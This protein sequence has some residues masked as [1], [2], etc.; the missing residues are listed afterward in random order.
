M[1]KL[2]TILTLLLISQVLHAQA[3]QATSYQAVIRNS[4]GN[5]LFNQLVKVR[6]SIHDSAA[7]GTVVYQ[8]TQTPTTNAQGLINLFAGQGTAVTGTFAGINWGNK[9]KF[10]QTEIDI[11]G[12]NNYADMGTTQLMSVPYALYSNNGNPNGTAVGEMLYW[13]GTTW[14][15]LNP[16]TN[17]QNLTF[18]NGVPQWGPCLILPIV[19]TGSITTKTAISATAG[20]N[21]TDSGSAKI[22]ARGVCFSTTINPTIANTKTASGTNVIGAYTVSLNGLSSL[23]TYHYRAYATTSVGTSYGAD[24]VFTTNAATIPTLTTTAASAITGVTATSGGNI[25]SDNG[26]TITARGIC[27]STTANPTITLTTKTIDGSGTGAFTSSIIGLATNTLYYVRA[28]ATNSAGTAYGTQVSFTTLRLSAVTTGAV[29]N[30]TNATATASGNVTDSGS[31]AITARGFCYATTPSPTI[32]N[33]TVVANGTNTTG[34][35]TVSLTG[36]LANTRYYV[37][38]YVTTS[39][40]TSY[41]VDSVFTTTNLVASL[42]RITIGTQV[43]TNKNLDV[44]TY[45]NGDPIPQVT[46]PTQWTNLTTGAWCWYNNDS[47]TYGATYGRLYNWYAVNDAR[48][49]APQGWHI[50]TDG[51]WNKLINYLDTDADT[52]CSPCYQS[53]IAAGAMKS[54]TGWNSPNTG[55]TNS[56]GFTGLPGGGRVTEGTFDAIGFIGLWWTPT[57]INVTNARG[58]KLSYDNSIVDQGQ[59]SKLIGLSVRCLRDTNIIIIPTTPTLTTTTTFT[60]ITT[61]S[62]TSGGKITYNGGAAITARGVCWSTIA[63]PT[64]SLSTKTVDGTGTGTFTSSITGLNVNTTYYVRAYATNSVGTAYGTQQTLTIASVA[65]LPSVTIGTQVWTNKNLD[66]TRYRNGDT[67]PH[68]TDAT[69]WAALTTGAWCWYNNDSTTYAA[70]Y[71][72]LYNWYAVNDARGLTPQGW[73]VPSEGDWNKLVKYLDTSADTTCVICSQSSI[74][75]GAMKST[76][77]WNSNGG[78]TNSSGYAGLS[79]GF[80]SNSGTFNNIGFAGYWWSSTEPITTNAWWYRILNSSSS[81]VNRNNS[82]RSVGLSVRCVKD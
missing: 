11:A 39:V 12:G 10:L 72:R 25:T 44:V 63:N 36:L 29:T 78:G 6:F 37:R 58:R 31:R 32:T 26:S 81:N 7:N 27:W 68:V 54:T 5:V 40:G 34:A 60:N 8:E 33:G 9:S 69:Q 73:H 52:S 59:L 23:T 55:A 1:K 62:A 41:G 3:P 35:F 77:G 16:G 66:V 2:I 42:P 71:G 64:V 56:S 19:L 38:A 76:T 30:I 49:L 45:R 43:W 53:S 65:F 79:G 48:I 28:Y 82:F 22:T 61:T 13:N 80:R 15:K 24:S 57:E 50:S 67:I 47:A 17:G 18:C 46:D 74:A 70:T 4:S 14:V 51:D 20:G 21:V 75:G